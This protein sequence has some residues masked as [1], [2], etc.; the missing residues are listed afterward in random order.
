MG[1][2]KSGLNS[3]LVLIARPYGMTTPCVTRLTHVHDEYGVLCDLFVV[4][5]ICISS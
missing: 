1:L 5:G 4:W 3:E 2:T